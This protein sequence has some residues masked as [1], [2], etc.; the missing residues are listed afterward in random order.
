MNES[1]W[2][3]QCQL[4]ASAIYFCYSL[5]TYI[6]R[7]PIS[8]LQRSNSESPETNISGY[9][10]YYQRWPHTLRIYIIYMRRHPQG[11]CKTCF[12]YTQ[13]RV[14]ELYIY[15]YACV[16]VRVCVFV[17]VHLVHFHYP[18]TYTIYGISHVHVHLCIVCIDVS[19]IIFVVYRVFI[20][21][22]HLFFLSKSFLN[23]TKYSFVQR[24]F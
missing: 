2:L 15:L 6:I 22:I 14:Q 9:H 11:G 12:S 5:Y 24:H 4:I 19:N 13:L 1:Y 7:V 3:L 20:V 23:F 17:C 21:F 16:C 18:P 8:K 10:Q